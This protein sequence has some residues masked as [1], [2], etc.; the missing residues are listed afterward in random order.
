MSFLHP[1]LLIAGVLAIALPIIIHLLFRQRRK[2]VRWAAMRFLLE[3]YRKRR[4]RLKLEHWILLAV[5]CLILACLAFALGRPLLQGAG[6][7]GGSGRDVYLLVDNALASSLRSVDGD[8]VLRSH[9]RT[10]K[11]LLDAL[12]PGDRAGLITLGSPADP[13][14]VPASSDLG[15]IARLID[16]LEPTDGATDIQG[17]LG[18]LGAHLE[19]IEDDQDPRPTIAAVVSEF[20]VG[21]ADPSRPLARSLA[22]LDNVRV[23]ATRPTDQ[24]AGNTQIVGIDPLRSVVLTGAGRAAEDVSVRVR[25]SRSGTAVSESG[26]TTVRLRAVEPGAESAPGDDSRATVRWTPGQSEA[27]VTMTVRL[28]RAGA[29]G[30]EGAGASVLVGSI[31]RDGIEG[32]NT[33]RTPVRITDALEVGVVGSRRFSGGATI[34]DRSAADWLRPALAPTDTTPVRLTD[35][36]PGGLDNA[37]LVGLDAVFV[38]QPSLLP[39]DAWPALRTFTD[40]GGLVVVM[41]PS[42]T[43]VHLWTDAFVGAFD[44][45]WS[46]PREALDA[47]NDGVFTIDPQDA[48][49]SSDAALL[50]LLSDELEQLLR[51]V[52]VFRVLPPDLS[53]ATGASALLRL[54]SGDA[55]LVAAQPGGVGSTRR[56]NAP[57][58]TDVDNNS[59]GRGVLLYLASAPTLAWTDLP[60]RPLMVPLMQELVRQGVGSSSAGQTQ[61][62]GHPIAV[63]AGAVTIAHST[64]D[65]AD[66]TI[67]VD[68]T[69]MARAAVRD[70]GVWQAQ[71]QAGRT[72][73]VVAV[74]A[75]ASAGRTALN[76]PE[77]LGAWLAGAF[78]AESTDRVMWLDDAQP[79]EALTAG[80]RGSPLS[81]PLLIAALALALLETCLARWFAHAWRE[82]RYEGVVA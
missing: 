55:W 16:E 49:S 19:S 7:L 42:D 50:T 29:M 22:G 25:L 37:A 79:G 56:A 14:V 67:D 43:T 58:G 61:R 12:G 59:P 66:R 81:L 65:G 74:N 17:A 33:V 78:D 21:S 26:V 73:G 18:A 4:R 35:L 52:G 20:R 40:R 53:G 32:D 63:G 39:E 45:A 47:P 11:D 46:F 24:L 71:D 34:A 72:R 80:D 57:S 6:L 23:L 82:P 69:G 51:P 70:A 64:P 13:V 1:G 9:Q 48:P 62:A 44:L 36:E 38:A 5:R 27:S 2:P 30:E 41:P 10:A 15:A 76:D 54:D 3:A 60:A 8:T 28:D 68:N 77:A 31:D 75:D